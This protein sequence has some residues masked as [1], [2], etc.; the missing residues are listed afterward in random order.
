MIKLKRDN[1]SATGK[2][3]IFELGD[4][5]WH[6]LEQPDN[7]NQPFISCVPVG[8][9]DLVPYK[10]KKYGDCYV[11]VNEDLNVYERKDSPGRPE[12]GRYKCL[13]SHRGNWVKNFQGC[14]GASHGYDESSD[15]LESS[16]RQACKEVNRLVKYEGSFKLRIEDDV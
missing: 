10:S 4:K 7:D 15:M 12:D 13:F 2:H 1:L 5:D 14:V 16:T 11:M 8:D 9:Y 3:G 6:S